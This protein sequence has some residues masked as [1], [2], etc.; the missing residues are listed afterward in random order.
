M[1]KFCPTYSEVFFK[2]NKK[3]LRLFF[4][5]HSSC[6]PMKKIGSSYLQ[7]TPLNRVV[8]VFLLIFTLVLP[9]IFLYPF[10]ADLELWQWI[11]TVFVRYGGLPY[12]GAWDHDFPGIVIVHAT[13]I[14][15][16]GNSML[17]FRSVEYV[18]IVI[19]IVALYRGSRLWLSETE[20]LMGC[21]VFALFYAY[22]RWDC[23]GQRDNF[24]VLPIIL[25]GFFFVQA[26]RKNDSRL[27]YWLIGFGGTMVGLAT[28]IR[29]TF[30]LL[31]AVPFLSLYRITNVRPAIAAIAGFC[32]PVLMMILPFALTPDGIRQAYLS[33]IRYNTDIYA[34]YFPLAMAGFSTYV[35]E[36]FQLR[37]FMVFVLGGVLLF[38]YAF[39]R[40]RRIPSVVESHRERSFI[41]HFFAA[42]L[43]GMFV[44]PTLSAC[45][46]TPF[47]A[48]FIPVLTKM[49]LD[50]SKNFGRWRLTAITGALIIFASV[51]YPWGLV[52]TFVNG[53]F[54]IKSA[55]SYFGPIQGIQEQSTIA[56]YLTK[57]TN[58]NEFIEVIGDPGISWR[59]PRRESS[60]FVRE[61]DFVF[62]ARTGHTTNYQREW[63]AAY[64]QS[65][66]RTSPRY[67]VIAR[68]P[69]ETLSTLFS[70]SMTHT[71][72]IK[73]FIQRSYQLET[74]YPGHAIYCKKIR[75]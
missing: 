70:I 23:M 74:L 39:R 38:V 42:L 35:R 47:Y 25:A 28:C 52:R 19:T 69:G 36:L 1:Q 30:A 67:I 27:E 22:G 20:S 66:Q 37:Q 44:Q 34:Q 11:A 63:R 57:H 48:C 73:D 51:L 68:D 40:A 53:K 6:Y 50:V 59:V 71:P 8:I 17:A 43:F 3:V 2:P 7:T 62:I 49:M 64:L 65:L 12:L 24:T 31:L 56:S 9:V 33:T 41:F 15:F 58:P 45:H 60:Q 13:A 10:N 4:A 55:Y 46:F 26:S 21:F 32:L 61:W 5:F 14:Y 75:S 54:S 29:P 18:T 72:E 16:L